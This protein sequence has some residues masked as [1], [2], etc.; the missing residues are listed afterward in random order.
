MMQCSNSMQGISLRTLIKVQTIECDIELARRIV[1]NDESAVNY[2][3]GE[4]SSAL[5]NYIGRVIMNVEATYINGCS[6]YSY[7]VAGEYYEFI[8]ASFVEG[9]PT[10]HKVALYKGCKNKGM[11]E[12]RLYSYISTITIRYFSDVRKK[13][14]KKE[15]KSLENMPEFLSLSIL[16]DYDGFDEIILEER[17]P[18]Y[19]ELSIV[20]KK[21]P[22]RDQLI[23]KYLVIEDK[24]PLE[25]F[26]EMIKYVDTSIHVNQYTRKQKQDAMSLMKRRAKL[27][28]RMLIEEYRKRK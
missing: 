3:L 9:V 17:N 5:L 22:K 20:W 4:F 23:L 1:S 11:K 27:H 21:L 25:I 15:A 28:L 2:F 26:D 14:K 6:C 10:W 12:A 13:I 16:K 19:A 18:M 24:E 7:A 8:A